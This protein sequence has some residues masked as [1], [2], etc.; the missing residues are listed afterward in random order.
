MIR[1]HQRRLVRFFSFQNTVCI[2]VRLIFAALAL[3][4]VVACSPNT[5]H[6]L[7]NLDQIDGFWTD[8][9][10]ANDNTTTDLNN[11]DH[12]ATALSMRISANENGAFA[13]TDNERLGCKKDEAIIRDLEPTAEDAARGK[14]RVK[15]ADCD[16]EQWVP[17]TLTRINDN[18][19]ELTIDCDDCGIEETQTLLRQ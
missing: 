6:L 16:K 2:M 19:I 10:G 15:K 13:T 9:A 4:T 14:M 8:E 7:F 17:V 3:Y 5:G 12:T 18:Q 1:I 11:T